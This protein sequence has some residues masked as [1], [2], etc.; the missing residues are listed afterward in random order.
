MYLGG[1]RWN[2][3]MTFGGRRTVWAWLGGRGFV[4]RVTTMNGRAAVCM[5]RFEPVAPNPI[6]HP[7]AG[8]R[9]RGAAAR[10]LRAHAGL[11]LAPGGA[12]GDCTDRETMEAGGAWRYSRA[13]ALALLLTA[14][15]PPPRFRPMNEML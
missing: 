2:E 12:R 9:D 13:R 4:G 15:P 10:Q 3:M 11:G 6:V 1:G 8:V 7:C 14:P 5:H